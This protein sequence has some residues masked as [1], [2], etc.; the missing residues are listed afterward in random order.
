VTPVSFDQFRSL[1]PDAVTDVDPIPLASASVAQIHRAKLKNKDVVLKFKRPGIEALIKEDIRLMKQGIPLVPSLGKWLDEFEK[2]LMCE[3]DFRGEVKN[4]A[5]FRDIY[6]DR[7]DIRIPRPYSSLSTNDLIVMDYQPSQPIIKP[8]RAERLINMFLEQLLYEGVI[9]GDLHSGNIG[10]QGDS[11]V[12]YDF[13][14]VI[15]ISNEYRDAIRKFVFGVQSNDMN[16]MIQAMKEMGMTIRDE[17]T[18]R[19]FMQKYL[20]Y[21][22]TLDFSEFRID[23]DELKE[24]F[25]KVPVE[26][27]PTT[28]VVLKSY[29]LLEG[30]CKEL[31][32]QFSYERIIQNNVELLFLNRLEN[33]FVN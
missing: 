29:S 13:G 17:E 5:K 33:L 32:P 7:S 23:S 24:K 26:L 19:L 28:L 2:S 30:L 11:I 10:R 16:E 15:T 21:L 25:S 8:F 18:T 4:I 1:I 6:R 22:M 31:D 9:H 14:N 20:N 27:D 3:L 12:M